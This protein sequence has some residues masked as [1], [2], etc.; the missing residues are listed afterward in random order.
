MAASAFE[1]E[2]LVPKTRIL[3][4]KLHRQN[5]PIS[6]G[7][8]VLSASVI[9][10]RLHSHSCCHLLAIANISSNCTSAK[11]KPN[12]SPSFVDVLVEMFGVEPK[13]SVVSFRDQRRLLV[14]LAGLEPAKETSLIRN[15]F[16]DSYRMGFW[17]LSRIFPR[18]YSETSLT[19][20]GDLTILV[21]SHVL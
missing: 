11:S 19:T 10:R 8:S 17:F 9:R 18:D 3:T 4:S 15:A 12:P 14:W 2:S 20:E 21:Q 5:A 13:S 6:L 1:T 7:A 16:V